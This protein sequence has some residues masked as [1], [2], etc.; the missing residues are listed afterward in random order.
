M[1]VAYPAGFDFLFVYWYLIHFVGRSPFSFSALDMKTYAAALL[2]LP[3]RNATNETGRS[4]GSRRRALIVMWLS[5][6]PK[7]RA[8]RSWQCVARCCHRDRPQQARAPRHA[9]RAGRAS[10][11]AVPLWHRGRRVVAVP[12][13]VVEPEETGG[14]GTLG[15][16][17]V[18]TQKIDDRSPGVERTARV[19]GQVVG[20]AGALMVRVGFLSGL[21]TKRDRSKRPRPVRRPGGLPGAARCAA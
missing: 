18:A 5:K 2:K 1:F 6:T 16:L 3:Y 13:L 7:S 15:L 21:L 9:R 11:S 12:G 20:H 4:A 10:R 14:K 19:V 17:V 8:T